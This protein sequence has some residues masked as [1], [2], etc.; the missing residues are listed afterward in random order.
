M[1]LK[2][3]YQHFWPDF[4]QNDNVFTW[5]LRHK[6]NVII[7]NN[8]SDLVISGGGP[9][10]KGIKTI[11]FSGE[12]FFLSDEEFIDVCDYGMSGYH[13]DKPNY[14]RFPLYL[15]YIYNFIRYGI[16][17][18]INF[19]FEER[20]PTPKT[21]FCNFIA[22]GLNGKR[23]EFFE[24]LNKY[25]IIDTNVKPYMNVNVPGNGGSINGS[26]KKLNFIRDYKFT[27]AFENSSINKHGDGYTTEKLVE[28][29]VANSLPI[30]WGNTRISE[31]FNTNSILSYFDYNNDEELIDKIIELDNNENLYNDYFKE[32]FI[33]S[34]QSTIID[35]EY[36]IN[37][38]DEIIKK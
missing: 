21:K 34:K 19:F 22:R 23:A 18:D 1:N 31:D 29:M 9:K 25:K 11:Y 12:P 2:V 24:K 28:P 33:T 4:N 15:Y 6:Y 14:Y 32:P 16:I 7:D 17:K 26:I 27:I 3:G 20:N 13:I 5:L 8:D 36:L 38:F 30:Y 10:R 37:I 35:I